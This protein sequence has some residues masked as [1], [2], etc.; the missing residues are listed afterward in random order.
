MKN[1]GKW[2]GAALL[3]AMTGVLAVGC[4]GKSKALPANQAPPVAALAPS[5]LGPGDELEIKFYYAPELNIQQR[6]R[7]DGKISLQLV[8]DIDAAGKTPGELDEALQSAFAKHLKYP[9]LSIIVRGMYSRR[10][11]VTG[12][13]LRPGPME[14]PA[15]M[16]LMEAIGYSGGFNLVTANVKQVIVSR[17]LGD[18]TGK[19]QGYVVNMKDEY[20][21]A[22][23]TPF[24]LQPTDIVIVPRTA[25]VEVN[26]F[27]QQYIN[28]N[29][30][31]AGVFYSKPVGNGTIT[32]DTRGTR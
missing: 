11:L 6:I 24:M 20:A 27:M 32:I 21:G 8:G 26:Q 30:P 2:T 29:I 19:R 13:V 16:T 10:V 3:V 7:S 14:M 12:E 18:G 5:K 28:N 22:A 31:D 23:T 17:D 25:V 1:F 9:E 15:Q 4:E